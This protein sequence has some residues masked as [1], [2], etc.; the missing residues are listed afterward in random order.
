MKKY[1]KAICT[2]LCAAMSITA[3][4]GSAAYSVSGEETQIPGVYIDDVSGWNGT[5]VTEGDF[6][7]GIRAD[8]ENQEIYEY[9]G[10]EAAY[11]GY[12]Y[13]NNGEDKYLRSDELIL[14]AYTGE[15]GD[16]VV[17]EEADGKKVTAISANVFSLND[18]VDT[19]TLPDGLDFIPEKAFMLSTIKKVNI[20]LSL[21]ILPAG[22]FFKCRMLEEAEGLEKVWLTADD[23]FFGTAVT[24]PP[25]VLTCSD[26]DEFSDGIVDSHSFINANY[27]GLETWI[28]WNGTEYESIIW[29]VPESD[30]E[31]VT[32]KDGETTVRYPEKICNIP[33]SSFRST[34]DMS[35]YNNY[36]FPESYSEISANFSSP[37]VKSVEFLNKNASFKGGFNS[38]SITEITLPVN[39]EYTTKMFENCKKL[40]SFAAAEGTKNAEFRYQCFNGCTSLE[41]VTVPD[42]C[43]TLS[44]DSGAFKGD[45]SLVTVDLPEKAYISLIDEAAFE[46]CKS[47]ESFIMPGKCPEQF[48]ISKD[49][50]KNCTSLKKVVFPSD[51]KKLIIHSGVFSGCTALT[52]I[53]LPMDKSVVIDSYAFSGVP[54]KSLSAGSSWIIDTNAFINN[55]TLSEVHLDGTSVGMNA[56]QHCDAISKLTIS[57]AAKLG[58][59]A[60]DDCAALKDI[61]IIGDD[62]KLDSG[63][64]N[65]PNLMTINGKT[66]F[67]SSTGDFTPEMK[68]LVT[69]KFASSD[70]IGFLNEYIRY[71]VKKTISEIIKPGMTEME[72]VKTIHDWICSNTRYSTES[73]PGYTDHNDASVFLLPST[74][75]DGYSRAFNLL[76][77]ES[78]LETCVVSNPSHA[79]NI[80]KI[81]GLYFHVDTTWDDE[82]EVSREW[83][84]KSDEEME[85][86]GGIHSSW[87]I[88]QPSALHSFQP[89]SLPE[90][91]RS[92]GDTNG[93]G[94]INAADLVRFSSYLLGNGG[95]SVDDAAVC[96]LNFDGTA[97]TFDIISLRRMLTTT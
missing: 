74:V 36:I 44:I 20:P 37:S 47:L 38:S 62:I 90:C 3:S 23:A 51:F 81:G 24:L 55:K 67:D 5:L 13:I 56:F 11:G 72:K 22:L 91:S 1:K 14:L 86:A 18:T 34:D 31:Y 41:T 6:I 69:E 59:G 95:L 32:K 58:K 64:F 29:Q 75:C 50:F 42:S 8:L 77:H 19:L 70:N 43:E 73:D 78:G 63:F 96:D 17:P 97:D 83:F 85:A 61:E 71:H 30:S 80:V 52:D 66:V 68:P 87:K 65:C 7:Y 46:G 60:F 39:T 2:A 26:V 93:D 88:D 33:L 35:V 48:T 82:D 84:L 53:E 21:K 15:G 4:A 16:V 12:L 54:V 57:G 27:K 40:K 9:S 92:M 94:S 25:E 28:Q 10:K 79:W 76:A 45:E 89:D 49:A